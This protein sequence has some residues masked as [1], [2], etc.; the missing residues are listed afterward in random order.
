MNQD[1]E[2]IEDVE[3]ED[4]EE[5]EFCGGLNGE[6]EDIST[7]EQVYAGEPHYA[8]IGSQRCPATLDDDEYEPED[9]DY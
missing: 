3:E 7:M 5:C 2:K 4:V 1:Q 9:R 8:P 6:H